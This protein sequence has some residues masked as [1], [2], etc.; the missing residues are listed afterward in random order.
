MST[1][2]PDRLA[3]YVGKA[4][5]RRRM[6]ARAGAMGLG[7]LAALTGLTAAARPGTPTNPGFDLAS[8]IGEDTTLQ[9]ACVSLTSNSFYN[10][11]VTAT[12]QPIKVD[13]QGSY[14]CTASNGLV[15]V[16]VQINAEAMISCNS[17]VLISGRGHIEYS[18]SQKSAFTLSGYTP[19][20]VFGQK[21]A[22]AVGTITRGPFRGGTFNY[23]SLRANNDAAAECLAGGSFT[24]TTGTSVVLVTGGS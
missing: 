1:D 8:T 22:H 18:D 14:N 4:T 21:V 11:A 13:S 17:V 16:R 20:M 19:V 15:A 3:Q 7:G 12:P 2:L 5:D 10:P 23:L 6:L 9:L 24:E